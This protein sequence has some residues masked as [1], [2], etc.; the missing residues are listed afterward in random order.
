MIF[1]Q[2]LSARYIKNQNVDVEKAVK[3][4][5]I[6]LLKT[7]YNFWSGI[8][9]EKDSFF[10]YFFIMKTTIAENLCLLFPL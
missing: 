5:D 9:L 6:Y 4:G 1:C 10:I 2:K 3:K 8:T 7:N